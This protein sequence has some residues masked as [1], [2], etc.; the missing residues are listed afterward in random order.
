[1]YFP[2]RLMA[3][4]L[5]G[6]LSK[7]SIGSHWASQENTRRMAGGVHSPPSPAIR[8]LSV[9]LLNLHLTMRTITK[10]PERM[11]EV[12]GTSSGGSYLNGGELSSHLLNTVLK[13]SRLEIASNNQNSE[14]RASKR[15]HRNLCD[16]PLNLCKFS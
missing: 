2:P 6:S 12:N 10:W 15:N 11:T 9:T 8:A 5:A 4:T 13:S 3:N 7:R 1:M 16:F 14:N